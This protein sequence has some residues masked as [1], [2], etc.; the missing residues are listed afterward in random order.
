MKIPVF[1]TVAIVALSGLLLFNL[2]NKAGHYPDR[3]CF[4]NTNYMDATDDTALRFTGNV[5]YEFTAQSTGVFDLTGI[6]TWQGNR[7]IF[8]RHVT[9]RYQNIAKNRYR[10]T[11]LEKDS[12]AHD[13]T[14]EDIAARAIKIIGLSSDDDIFLHEHDNNTITLGTPLFPSLNCVITT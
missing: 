4:A 9:F 2:L 12:L 5:N 10:I 14:P 13:N 11:V 7:Y 1:L 8:S 3:R 6:L